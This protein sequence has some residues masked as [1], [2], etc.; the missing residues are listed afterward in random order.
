MFSFSHSSRNRT[1]MGPFLYRHMTKV[2]VWTQKARPREAPRGPLDAGK[3]VQVSS[4]P[5]PF[6]RGGSEHRELTPQPQAQKPPAKR[7]EGQE[8]PG[9]QG[10]LWT[11][12]AHRFI[13]S[14]AH[15]PDLTPNSVSSI[16]NLHI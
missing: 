8:P 14:I 11:K 16:P 12:A 3:Q 15:I 4:Q 1:G 13:S 5:S 10:L 7:R 9:V 2:L 6:W